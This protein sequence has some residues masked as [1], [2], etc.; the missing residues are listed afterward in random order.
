MSYYDGQQG[1]PMGMDAGKG[2]LRARSKSAASD[3]Q[4]T[5]DGRPILQFG[6]FRSIFCNFLAGFWKNQVKKALTFE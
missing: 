4:F 1:A 5:K 6:E 2:D 3:R